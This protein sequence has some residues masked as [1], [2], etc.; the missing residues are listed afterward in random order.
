MGRYGALADTVCR[1]GRV[2]RGYGFRSLRLSGQLKSSW[3][4]AH[5]LPMHAVRASG[6]SCAGFANGLHVMGV[7]GRNTLVFS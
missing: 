1:E 6:R 2:R 4:R 3:I 7:K 5:D